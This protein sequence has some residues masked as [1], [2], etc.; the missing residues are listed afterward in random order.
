MKTVFIS[1]PFSGRTE[2]EIFDERKTIKTYLENIYG[3]D[4]VIID[5]YHQIKPNGAGKFWYLSQDI[6]MMEKADIICF[7]KNWEKAKG[8]RVE[9][10]LVVSYGLP[11]LIYP[12]N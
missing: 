4:V 5:Q 9:H 11:Y 2:K 6:L 1:Q 8:C 7:S 10:E 3:E 12:D